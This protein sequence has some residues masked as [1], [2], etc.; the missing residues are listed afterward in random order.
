MN[1]RAESAAPESSEPLKVMITGGGT[2][3]HVYPGLA[4]AAAL[5]TLDPRTTVWFAGTKRGLEA[6]L[7]PRAGYPLFTLPASG[8]RGMGAGARLRFLGNFAAGLVKGVALLMRLRPDVVLGTGGY[9]AAPV[10]AAARLLRIPTALQEQNAVPGAANK[11]LS[12]WAQRI[13]LGFGEAAAHFAGRRCVVTGNPVRA[14]F[15]DRELDPGEDYVSISGDGRFLKILVFGGSSG[16]H[17]LNEAVREAAGLW[18]GR[19]TIELRLQ[20]GP[21]DLDAVA[22]AY[23]GWPTDQVTVESYILDMPDALRRA[24]LVICRAGAMTLAELAA[25]GRPAILVPFP[26]ATD[27]HQLRNA[28]DFEA[29]GA[30][31]V[32][33]DRDCDGPALAAAVAE[34]AGDPRRMDEMGEACARRARPGAAMEIATDLMRLTGRL[35]PN[36]ESEPL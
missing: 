28:R 21:K 34:L 17:T 31:I 30:A 22:E 24:D 36:P 29:D 16:A 19:E 13:Y 25:V 1:D 20:T 18:S 6:A 32:I 3:G 11:L 5:Q 35:K 7:V 33:E 9:A 10:M 23:M 14:E 15:R 27:D 4:V 2:G 8:F 12:R 26:H